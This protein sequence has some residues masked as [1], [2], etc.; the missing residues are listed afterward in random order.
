MSVAYSVPLHHVFFALHPRVNYFCGLQ[1]R[2]KDTDTERKAQGPQ[3]Q[4]SEPVNET[5]KISA[6]HVLLSSLSP[7]SPTLFKGLQIHFPQSEQVAY[8]VRIGGKKRHKQ[9]PRKPK[10]KP[11]LQLRSSS[12]AA[13]ARSSQLQLQERCALHI[14]SAV[15]S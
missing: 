7:R 11:T 2:K 13:P 10:T 6:L 1:G 5:S 3:P 12:N 15:F 4:S 14:Q 8:Q 9:T